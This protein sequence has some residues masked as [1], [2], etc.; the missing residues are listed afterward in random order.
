MKIE[1]ITTM[2]KTFDDSITYRTKA[3]IYSMVLKDLDI[4]LPN[5]PNFSLG[6]ML[7]LRLHKTS[8]CPPGKS[9]LSDKRL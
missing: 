9:G 2:M 1:H 4:L 3:K 8:L 5:L 7:P 6:M